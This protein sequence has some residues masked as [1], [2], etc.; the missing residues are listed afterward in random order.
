MGRNYSKMGYYTEEYFLE[1]NVRYIAV[2]DNV[3]QCVADIVR[4]VFSMYALGESARRIADTF[5]KEGIISPR[6]YSYKS[7]G[8]EPLSHDQICWNARS[9]TQL[10]KN[11]VYIGNMVQGKRQ[12]VSFKTKRRAATPKEDWII[13][14]NTHEPIIDRDTWDLV[15]SRY[16]QQKKVRV[17]SKSEVSLF[18]GLVRCADCGAKLAYNTKE[19]AN[20]TYHVYRCSTYANKGSNACSVHSIR[21]ELLENTVFNELNAFAKL[22]SEQ[23]DELVNKLLSL[24]Q[25]TQRKAASK[26]KDQVRDIELRIATIDSNIKKLFEE[27]CSGSVP[28]DIFKHLMSEYSKEKS[29]ASIRLEELSASIEENKK[30]KTM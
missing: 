1:H 5:N 13:I 2:N 16:N 3:D 8:K 23:E 25:G 11:E 20:T 30:Q 17:N 21:S 4:R 27:K 14:E 22:A 10:M 6:A 26:E 24:M 29:N 12:V 15:Q 18:S 9:I 28:D 19:N 7:E